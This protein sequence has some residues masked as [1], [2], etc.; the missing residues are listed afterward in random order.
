MMQ[1]KQN[2]IPGYDMPKEYEVAWLTPPLL[3]RTLE[4][5]FGK[6]DFDPC[7]Y[8]RP[9]GFDGLIADWGVNN[10]VNPPF[11][12]GP[13]GLIAWVRKAI[14]ESEKGKSTT[15]VWPM[16]TWFDLLVKADCK[17]LSLGPIKWLPSDG[18]KK[19]PMGWPVIAFTLQ[20]DER[21]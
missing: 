8:P 12:Y 9:A 5:R 17:L 15:L 21:D 13:N 6:F 19:K 10:Y 1:P 18:S 3:M 2:R 11:K 16:P 20:P 7:P 4:D 14:E